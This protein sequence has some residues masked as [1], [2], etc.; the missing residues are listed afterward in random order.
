[1]TEGFIGFGSTRLQRGGERGSLVLFF[2]SL[3]VISGPAVLSYRG[4]TI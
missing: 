2:F 3:I 1:M 4:K